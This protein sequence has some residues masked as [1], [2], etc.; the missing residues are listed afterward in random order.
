MDLT[1]LDKVKSTN[2]SVESTAATIL[3]KSRRENT[4]STCTLISRHVK[5]PVT[6]PHQ[7]PE[8]EENYYRHP[9]CRVFR[10]VSVLDVGADSQCRSKSPSWNPRSRKFFD[11]LKTKIRVRISS[12]K[13]GQSS[14]G[15]KSRLSGRLFC[16]PSRAILF[17]EGR[18]DYATRQY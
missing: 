15:I 17:A 3:D 4:N 7:D 1:D 11:N 8:P 14:Q 6:A 9:K 2:S 18:R 12:S 10:R 16:L 5:S 13:D